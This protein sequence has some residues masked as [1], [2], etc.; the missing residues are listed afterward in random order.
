M[1]SLSDPQPVPGKKTPRRA[2]P[3]QPDRPGRGADAEGS[4]QGDDEAAS[5]RKHLEQ[6]QA[7]VDNV[8]EGYK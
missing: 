3:I 7:A 6:E 5:A 4:G 1:S 2:E 8:R